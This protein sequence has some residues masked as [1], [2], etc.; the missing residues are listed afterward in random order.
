RPDSPFVVFY[1]NSPES[2]PVELTGN[3]V[4]T[5]TEGVDIRKITIQLEGLQKVSWITN[6][7]NP[8]QMVDKKTFLTEDSAL[9]PPDAS[10]ASTSHKIN[11]GVHKWPFKFK[12]PTTLPESV[13]GMSGSY[14]IYNLNATV[15]RGYM[16]R[17]LTATKRIRLVRTLGV[18]SLDSINLEQINEDVWS[19]KISYRITVPRVNYIFGTAITADFILTPIKKG[20]TIGNI[21][22]ELIETTQ[23]CYQHGDRTLKNKRDEVICKTEGDMPENCE[24]MVTDIH[25]ESLCDESYKFQMTLPLERS[26]KKCRQSFDGDNIKIEH[27][28]KIYVSLHNPEGHTSQLLV[29][30]MVNLFISPRLPVGDDQCVCIS[31]ITAAQLHEE[32]TSITAPPSYDEHQLDL[33]YNDID[34]SGLITPAP[35]ASAP[36]SGPGTPFYSLSRNPSNE[37]IPSSLNAI[38]HSNGNSNGASASLLHTRLA[39]L[40][41][42]GA[43]QWSRNI[44]SRN[45][46]GYFPPTTLNP[47]TGNLEY[48]MA[49]LA[50]IPSYN[51]AVRTPIMSSHNS[52][53]GLPSYAAATSTHPS[54]GTS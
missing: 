19:N 15:D 40:Q 26:L 3:V 46:S 11:P 17:A 54:P 9:F 34:A 24:V 6:A 31:P 5:N 23:V 42:N 22:L 18:D 53:V 28:L 41:E 33:L 32:A 8:Q 21:K 2:P 1:G 39:H 14:I 47:D 38:A 48:D 25:P 49:A 20:V 35:W 52:Q 29:K 44:P 12:L 43:S 10:M 4:L 36:N 7:V 37:D 13:E 50:R 27:R 16:T 30:N 45:Q 51:T